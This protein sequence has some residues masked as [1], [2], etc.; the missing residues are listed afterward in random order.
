MNMFHCPEQ[1]VQ[2][3]KLNDRKQEEVLP[4][5]PVQTI[6]KPDYLQSQESAYC[7]TCRLFSLCQISSA[8]VLT[9]EPGRRQRLKMLRSKR[10]INQMLVSVLWQDSKVLHTWCHQWG[11]QE[12]GPREPK[13]RWNGG[14]CASLDCNAT[15]S[16]WDNRGGWQGH[17]LQDGILDIFF[18]YGPQRHVIGLEESFLDF[19]LATSLDAEE[20]KKQSTAWKA[21]D[22]MDLCTDP[23][24]EH[25]W[26][27]QPE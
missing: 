16:P 25:L 1:Q 5:W 9:S 27:G 2:H 20:K 19:K 10:V 6:S 13:R 7:F 26:R 17:A 11:L 21:V 3:F 14:W 23:I 22:Y 4:E 8:S 12:K 24:E 18:K 15:R